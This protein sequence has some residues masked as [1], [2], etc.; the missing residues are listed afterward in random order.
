MTRLFAFAVLVVAI[1]SA[2]AQMTPQQATD[3]A[4]AYGKPRNDSIRTTINP[5]NAATTVPHYNTTAPEASYFGGG[6]GNLV[7]PGTARVADCAGRENDPDPKVRD[8]CRAINDISRLANNPPPFT[9]STSDPLIV[10]SRA[11][12]NDPSS[13]LGSFTNNLGGSY[14]GCTTQTTSTGPVFEE[15]VC[16]IYAVDT[17]NACSYGPEIVTDPDYLYKCLDLQ[18]T[19]TQAQCTV[20][21]VVVVDADAN[22]VCNES[23]RKLDNLTCDK[24]L[25]IEGDPSCN[26]GQFYT[27]FASDPNGLGQDPCDGGDNLWLNYQ[28]TEVTPPTLQVQTNVKNQPNYVFALSG[29]VFDET[30]YFSNCKG[31][32]YG[33]TTCGGTNCSTT[34]IM[35]VSYWGLV[36]VGWD[37]DGMPIYEPGWAYSG[38]LGKVFA[39]NTF[40]LNNLRDVWINNCTVL[41]ARQ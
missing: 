40:T 31:R 25:T 39:Y 14:S 27:A 4:K 13:V 16:H 5:T 41:E 28:C 19:E 35:E 6:Q 21:R 34:I 18:R 12:R 24:V 7:T 2:E 11:A 37:Q 38:A 26:I 8:S 33:N 22:Y 29:S 1:A 10:N 9:L 20:G 36:F 32:F 30:H 3:D 15:E 23:P 17:T